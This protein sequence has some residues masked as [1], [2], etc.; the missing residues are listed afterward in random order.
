M[1]SSDP[2]QRPPSAGSYFWRAAGVVL[3]PLVAVPFYR[4]AAGPGSDRIAGDVV[5]AADV[6]RTLLLLGTLI[7]LTLGVLASKVI[8]PQR[9]ESRVANAGRWLVS[10]RLPVYAASLA[11]LSA[12]LCL[13]FSEFVLH[14]KPN[15]IDAMVQLTQARYVA[16]GR[17]SGPVDAFSEFWYLPNSIVTSNGW[18]SQYPP[19]H[20]LLLAAG[21]AIGSPALTGAILVAITVFFSALAAELL[22]PDDR[23]VARVGALMLALSPFLLGL[24]GA[25]MNHVA[26]AAFIS[27]AVYCALKS[28]ESAGFMWAMVTGAAVGVVFS[29]RPLTAI[30]AALVVATI[31]MWWPGDIRTASRALPKQVLGAVIGIAPLIIGVAAYNRHFFGSPLR[32]GYSAL[33]G[34][35]VNPGFHRD[36]SGHMY[37]AV[38]ALEYTSSDLTTLSMYLLESPIPACAVVALFL[39]LSRR[40]SRGTKIVACWALLPILANALYWH[41]GF[42]MGPRMMNEWTAS[43]VL[44]SAVAAV[45]L[46]RMISPRAQF[47]GYSIRAGVAIAF[48]LAW[49]T[50]IV[51]LGPQRLARY[52]GSFL[53]SSRIEVPAPRAPS[54]VFVHGGWSTRIATRLSSHG[55]RGDSLEAAMALNPTCDVQT[56]ANWYAAPANAR[57][58]SAP[59]LNFDFSSGSRPE[60]MEIAKGDDIRLNQNQ[61]LSQPCLAQVASDTLG[62][63]D[64]AP[65][66]WQYDLP[67][68]ARSGAMVV[69]DMGPADNAKLIA[70]Y[71]DR[72]PMMLLRRVKEGSPE[73][74][75]YDD[76]VKLLWPQG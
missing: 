9:V 57:A 42:F 1:G 31:W 8:D 16:A 3:L 11:A 53:A 34:P 17:L 6:A 15:L 35:L 21:M 51:Y 36:P 37:G 55:L 44:L 70:R 76:A 14:G 4:L 27:I 12:L 38:Q 73:L 10:I 61:P 41:H 58:G 72:V 68:L 60:R 75:R 50:G 56:F 22:F 26:A 13:A 43:W 7:T 18:V 47:S 69:R 20:V 48:L 62:I 39:I 25:F 19:G 66:S 32:F 5:D 24:A 2:S 33:V 67:G 46:V 52:G 45:G 59:P 74:L 64:I 40:L 71:P 30:V 63:I 28:A 29:I 65:L 49:I 23:A 54:L